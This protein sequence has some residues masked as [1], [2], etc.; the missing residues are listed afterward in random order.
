MQIFP[1]SRRKFRKTFLQKKINFPWELFEL[2]CEIPLPFCKPL[3]LAGLLHGS[4]VLPFLLP[5]RPP[6]PAVREGPGADAGVVVLMPGVGPDALMPHGLTES[7]LLL[8]RNKYL[9]FERGV[10]NHFW[11]F[12]FVVIASAN[13]GRIGHT[14][15]VASIRLHSCEMSA[16]C[17]PGGGDGEGEQD[18]QQQQHEEEDPTQDRDVDSPEDPP[19]PSYEEAAAMPDMDLQPPPPPPEYEGET[20]EEE[21]EEVVVV[22]LGIEAAVAWCDRCRRPPGQDQSEGEAGLRRPPLLRPAH[23]HVR[24]SEI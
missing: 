13:F 14:M 24:I 23:G 1:P 2:N 19:P 8:E 3:L 10:V 21:E 7:I 18:Q 6:L 20:E 16:R 9:C 12:L 5:L 11:S 15:G 4:A 22:E 17:Q